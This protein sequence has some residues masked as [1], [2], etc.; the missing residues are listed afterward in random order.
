MGFQEL[1][2][3]IRV[4]NALVQVVSRLL[5]NERDVVDAVAFIATGAS[6]SEASAKFNIDKLRLKGIVDRIRR[7]CGLYMWEHIYISAYNMTMAVGISPI[8]TSNGCGVPLCN[9]C[10]KLIHY[11]P[12]YHVVRVHKDLVNI[13]VDNILRQLY[14]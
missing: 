10:N 13:L 4:R 6:L 3:D 5:A 1:L 11:S 14:R 8:I 9:L 2:N 12:T 7:S